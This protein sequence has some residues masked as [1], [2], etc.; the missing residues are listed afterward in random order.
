MA[1]S[2]DLSGT[3]AVVSGGASGIGAGIVAG[4]R[5]AGATVTVA[6]IAGGAGVAKLDVTDQASVDA[7]AG[8]LD[9]VDI[10]VNAAGIIRRMAEYDQATFEQ[11]LAVNLTGTM[12]L[13]TA[14]RPHLAAR[15]GAILNIAS[16]L[17]FFGAGAA[18]G[19]G[20][21]KGGIA[22]LTKALAVGWAGDDIRV[23][24]LAPGWIATPLTQALRDDKAREAAI[25]ARTPLGRWGTPQDMAGAAVF[26][27]SPLASFVTGA[28][29]PVDG[30]YLVA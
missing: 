11:V 25:L 26:L 16:M 17:S 27:C 20:A 12:R 4:L 30:G 7:L 10:L 8:S 6:D 1:I 15:G 3:Q 21:S 9:R 22:Q 19:Y 29:V 28:I 23:N 18:P 14:L 13:S 2:I 5:E 24:A